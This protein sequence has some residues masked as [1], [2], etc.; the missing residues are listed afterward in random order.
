VLAAYAAARGLD[1]LGTIR[2]TDTLVRVFSNDFAP[3]RHARGAALFALDL[4]PPLRNF[5][6]RRM[7][8]GAR[9]WP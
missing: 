6:A 8:F 9:A 4:V 5:V 1:R 2:F 3:L 7:M